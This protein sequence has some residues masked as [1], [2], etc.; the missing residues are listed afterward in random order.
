[1]DTKKQRGGWFRKYDFSKKEYVIDY[2]ALTV[3][4]FIMLIF[5]SLGGAI[6]QSTPGKTLART[7]AN[8]TEWVSKHGIQVQR[9]SCAHD[10]DSDGYG[11]CTIVTT[12]GEKIFLQCVGGWLTSAF[13]GRGCKEVDTLIKL[14]GMGR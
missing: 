4:A 9:L 2:T 13:G 11:S 3:I 14:N 1:M 8:V 10:S 7:E 5:V 12:S 6:Y